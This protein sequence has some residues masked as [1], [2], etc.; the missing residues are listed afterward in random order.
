MG[1][2]DFQ[3]CLV[4]K[5]LCKQMGLADKITFITCPTQREPDGLA[6][7]SRNR[8]LSEAQRSRAGIIYQCLVSIQSKFLL[9][10]PF[11]IV[12]KECKDL[13]LNKKIEPEYV[14]IANAETLEP[15]VDYDASKKMV[16][17]IAAKVG[18]VR[19]IDNILL[20]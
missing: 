15:L 20:N 6:M 1:S 19:L 11:S 16:A 3:Q 14:S 18:E 17:L 13:M 4:V 10:A 12:E 8:R 2:K 7:S 9:Q 5:D